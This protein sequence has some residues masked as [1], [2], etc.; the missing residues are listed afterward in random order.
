MAATAASVIAAEQP[1]SQVQGKHDIGDITMVRRIA[2]ACCGSTITS[3]VVTPL[4]VVRVRLQLQDV[5]ALTEQRAP[6]PPTAYRLPQLSSTQFA[7]A[8]LGVTACCRD[9]FNLPSSV[10]YCIAS[11]FDQCAVEQHSQRHVYR[12]TF[13]GLG[14]IVQNEGITALWR[15]LSPTLAMSI[16]NNV[17]YFVGYDYLRY[18]LPA[19]FDTLA[20]MIAGGGA[21]I[22]STSVISP[23]ELFRTRLQSLS[24]PLTSSSASS[25]GAIAP[26]SS[27]EAFIM[28]W[29]GIRSLVRAE[30]FPSLWRGLTL[31]L[32]RDVPFSAVYWTSYERWQ[33]FF[34]AYNKNK[35]P[36][37]ATETFLQAFASGAAAGSFA[38]F[39]TTPFD[40]G[41]T[42]RQVL[43]N[44]DPKLSSMLSLLNHIAK[45]E[46]VQ[47]LF[48]G[49][50]PR[51][52][53][54]AVSCAVMISFYEVGKKLTLFGKDSCPAG[55]SSSQGYTQNEVKFIGDIESL[56]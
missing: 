30:G 23:I 31:S 42:R 38:A 55:T 34:A 28:T 52:M 14:K 50:V 13:D 43:R 47:G 37:G 2:A 26:K 45:E 18:K 3:L 40:V 11:S 32:W 7:A 10:D 41:K 54:V 21:R 12:G 27:R 35:P 46:G 19:S 49:I 20:P 29:E 4:D 36:P 22:L 5:T 56:D 48:R 16:P 24:A 1:E 33:R 8:D 44:K 39:V 25:I 53:K 51:M 6:V 9:V 17:I 15:G